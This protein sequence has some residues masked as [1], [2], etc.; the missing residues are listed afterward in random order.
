MISWFPGDGVHVLADAGRSHCN[1]CDQ[2]LQVAAF[3]VGRMQ[4]RVCHACRV[5]LITALGRVGTRISKRMWLTWVSTEA[6]LPP[7]ETPVLAM[8]RGKP[9]IAELRWEY[10]GFE[11]TFKAYRYW[12]DPEEPGQIW[13]WNDVTYWTP[14]PEEA[15]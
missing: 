10:P 8:V 12:D 11:D 1:G 2:Y 13:E 5:K 15:P 4:I 3:H 7:D 14:L 6:A 9:R